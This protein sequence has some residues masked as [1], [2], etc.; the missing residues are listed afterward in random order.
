MKAIL[1]G[2]L[3]L[4]SCNE[5]KDGTSQASNSTSRPADSASATPGIKTVGDLYSIRLP[6]SFLS[7]QQW[8]T[9]VNLEKALGKPV[10]Q[11]IR[12]LDRNS[13]TFAGSFIK[14]LEYEGLKLKLFSPKQ[15]GK[16]FWVQ[17]IILTSG[18]YKTSRDVGIGDEF[19]KLK[20]AYPSLQKFP[21]ENEHMY[22]IANEG[23]DKSIEM[24][25][26]NNRLLKL[27]MY[28]MLN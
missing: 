17:E 5:K 1:I 26:D 25:F 20:Q 6:D 21:G 14:E 2:G 24:E 19:E 4:F 8:D 7:L 13:D 9:A 3:L 12:Q 11:K 22:Y 18:K 16:S 28:Y 23:Y 15:N 27:R 10:K